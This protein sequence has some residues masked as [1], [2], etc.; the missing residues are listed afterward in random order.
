MNN[1][2][3]IDLRHYIKRYVEWIQ[4][5][6]KC[7]IK[8]QST[9]ML[10]ITTLFL[11]LFLFGG[12]RSI[13]AE[14]QFFLEELLKKADKE[15]WYK[16][17]NSERIILIAKDFIGK[18]YT[19][20]TLENPEKEECIINVN[21]VDCFTFVEAVININRMITQQDYNAENLINYVEQMR[22]RK[23][24]NFKHLLYTDRL[25]YTGEWLI[26]NKD[27]GIFDD[28]SEKLGGEKIKFDLDFMSTHPDYYPALVAHPE[29]IQKIAAI[30]KEV[31]ARTFYYIPKSRVEKAELG[32]QSGDIVLITSYKK[33]LDFTHLGFAYKDR[34]SKKDVRFLHASSKQKE[35]IIDQSISNY[36]NND[37]R[38][39]GITVYRLN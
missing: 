24:S 30:E 10:F 21:E 37:K 38:L 32:L 27:L 4:R 18:K 6:T 29:H 16:K 17:S 36:L 12:A 5:N 11:S 28:V 33:G 7:V 13:A 22:Y 39:I 15:N 25:H 26:Q 23:N 35:V 31:S 2:S 14:K 9:L 20:K 1:I 34:D 3:S 19:A 8:K